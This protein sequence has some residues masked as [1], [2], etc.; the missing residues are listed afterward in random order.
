MNISRFV[1]KLQSG[2]DF[3]K[4]KARLSYSQ[5]GE[6]LLVDYVLTGIAKKKKISF[7][8]IGTNDP[9]HGNNTYLFYVRQLYGVCIEPDPA[10]YKKIISKRSK[11]IVLNAGIGTGAATEGT[12]CIFPAGYTGWNTF[13]LE[14]AEK[15]HQESGV[16]FSLSEKIPFLAINEVIAKYFDSAPDFI[17]IDVEGLDFAILQTLDFE[18]NKPLVFCVETISFSTANKGQKQNDITAFLL[19]HGYSIY[20]DTYVNT[21]FVRQEIFNP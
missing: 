8:D 11:D 12:L 17:S 6:D 20:A 7:L 5:F 4:G 3:L 9:V 1:R 15:R 18:K 19:S 14:E 10:I 16:I 2:A 13:S 21:I